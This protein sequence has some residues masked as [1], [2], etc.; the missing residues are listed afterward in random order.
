MTKINLKPCPCCGNE[1]FYAEL[2]EGFRIYCL[3]GVRTDVFK[4]KVK[5]ASI[6]N[7]RRLCSGKTQSENQSLDLFFD[8]KKH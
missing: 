7:Y 4:S 1:A 3:C 6:W 5:A 2:D 8:G